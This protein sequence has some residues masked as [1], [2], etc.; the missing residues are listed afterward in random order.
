[1]EAKL[2]SPPSWKKGKKLSPLKHVFIRLQN[3]HYILSHNH[4]ILT[5]PM[6]FKPITF[7]HHVCSYIF[8]I[9]SFKNQ[10]RMYCCK[11]RSSE[12]TIH[13]FVEQSMKRSIYITTL[14]ITHYCHW[15]KTN[16]F[17]VKHN[18]NTSLRNPQFIILLCSLWSRPFRS[19]HY[20]LT[21]IA[22]NG[23]Q[24]FLS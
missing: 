13:Q 6:I 14:P 22:I 2:I 19:Q 15:R 9:P 4:A 7:F 24:L 10:T 3:I 23:K 18:R 11:Q 12:F 17:I 5:C 16:I 8:S 20:P 1:V 21:A